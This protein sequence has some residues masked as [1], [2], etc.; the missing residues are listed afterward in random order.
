M[1]E[2]VI[3]EYNLSNN[4]T[5]LHEDNNL[6]MTHNRIAIYPGTLPPI[7]VCPSPVSQHRHSIVEVFSEG[8]TVGGNFFDF[9][10]TPSISAI[11]QLGQEKAKSVAVEFI[12]RD[13]G[14][15]TVTWLELTKRCVSEL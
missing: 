9:A 11:D 4:I 1:K 2:P 15:Y 7:V 3:D 13:T 12:G 5:I 10:F 14:S 8:W 6:C